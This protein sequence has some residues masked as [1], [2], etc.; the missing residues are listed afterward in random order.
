MSG[1]KQGVLTQ[2]RLVRGVRALESMEWKHGA[3]TYLYSS[4]ACT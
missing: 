2:K 3:H 4:L 1:R